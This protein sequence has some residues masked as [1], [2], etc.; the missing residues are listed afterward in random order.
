MIIA[1]LVILSLV[2]STPNRLLAGMEF[3]SK[4]KNTPNSVLLDVRTPAEYGS[5]HI[6]SAINIDYDNTGLFNSGIKKLDPSKT[7]FVYCRS[8]NRS[9]KAIMIMKNNSIKDVYDLKGGIVSSPE[10]L[11]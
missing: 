2:Q 8:G 5:G 7:Y 1:A 6:E 11:K 10:L 9:S 3:M 4:Y